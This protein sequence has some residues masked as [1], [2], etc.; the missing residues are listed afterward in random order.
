MFDR[1]LALALAVALLPAWAALAQTTTPPA[2]TPPADSGGLSLGETVDDADGPGSTY[3]K[4]VFGDWQMNCERT[5]SGADP[6]ELYQLLKDDQGN[7]VAEISLFGLPPG[8]QAVA[9]ATIVTPLETLLTAQVTMRV[10]SSQAKRYP[11][12]LCVVQGCVARV[13]FTQAEVDAFKRGN[14]ATITIVPALAP[15]QQVP[16]TMSL[17]GFTA[18]FDAV[19]KANAAAAAAEA[20]QPAATGD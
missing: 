13:G 11:F 10:D 2:D 4:E 6:C 16:L 5:E 3:V 8:S 20:A 14:V 9:G 12:T 18:G 17:K 1:P 15:D 7:S 19:N